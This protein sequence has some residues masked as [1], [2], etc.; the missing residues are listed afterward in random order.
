MTSC[1]QARVQHASSAGAYVLVG[2]LTR[3][4][5]AFL[6]MSRSGKGG[7]H[8][9]T[10]SGSLLSSSRGS[11]RCSSMVL[12]IS[13]AI[14]GRLICYA[15]IFSHMLCAA[16]RVRAWC[17]SCSRWLAARRPASSSLMRSMPLVSQ[18]TAAYAML[19]FVALYALCCV[20]LYAL[21]CAVS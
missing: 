12:G 13:P 8:S 4:P 15:E 20:A 21:C 14:T 19:C 17:V 16:C 2:G 3:L 9:R 18:G 1:C 10:T 7:H 6:E 5:Y 11:R